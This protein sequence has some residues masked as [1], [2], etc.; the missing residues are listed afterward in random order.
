MYGNAFNADGT[1]KAGGETVVKNTGVNWS[2]SEL[3]KEALAA[4]LTGTAKARFEQNVGSYATPEQWNSHYYN[5]TEA[6]ATG[7]TQAVSSGAPSSVPVQMTLPDGSTANGYMTLNAKGGGT[8][9]LDNGSRPPA[10]T[11][12]HTPNAG[13][14]TVK[15]SAPITEN[16]QVDTSQ[17]DI[18]AKAVADA[19]AIED[20]K[21]Q[22]IIEENN[23]IEQERLN[24]EAK[25]AEDARLAKEAEDKKS[26][27]IKNEAVI[28]VNGINPDDINTVYITNQNGESV[29]C[30][31][32][33]NGQI[34]QASDGSPAIGPDGKEVSKA[35][36]DN[37]DS[38]FAVSNAK[39]D[40]EV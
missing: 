17:E 15:S 8:T 14:F 9:F 5:G 40:R 10:D 28:Q 27:V 35:D 2:N 24:A 3:S 1:P 36:V 39:S 18:N 21:N 11:V 22:A 16:K 4:A 26:E 30:K 32:L 20:A 38:T 7:G 12:V 13:D 29:K 6:M 34:V 19:K 33:P 31:V 37:G 25:A 23:R